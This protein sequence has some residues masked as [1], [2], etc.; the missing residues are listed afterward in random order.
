[1]PKKK[2]LSEEQVGSGGIENRVA[3]GKTKLEKLKQINSEVRKS[4][5]HSGS[6]RKRKS[7]AKTTRFNKIRRSEPVTT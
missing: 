3:G 5:A 4:T 6:C 7:C 2:I 1:M